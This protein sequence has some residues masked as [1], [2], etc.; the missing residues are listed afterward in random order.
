MSLLEKM[1]KNSTIKETSIL[2]T[3]KFFTK[4]DVIPTSIPALNVALSGNLDGGMVPGISLFCGPSK[5]F[6]SFFC[7]ILAKAY[8]DKYPDSVLVFYDCE[9]GTPDT[10]FQS[11]NMDTDRILHTPIMNM[12]EF[13]FDIMKHLQNIT[14]EDK[15]IFVVDSIGSMSSLKEGV[16]AIE[17]KSTQDMTR[18]KQM[19]SIFRMVTP[20]LVRNDIPLVAVNH[21]YMEQGSMYPKTIVSGGTGIYLSADNIYIMGRQQEKEGTEVTGYNFIINIEKSRHVR[22]KSKIPISVKFEGGISR[23]SGLIDMALESGHVIKPSNGW[24]SRVNIETGEVEEKKYRL[25]D[26]D[27]K[28]FWSKIL[29]DKTF[30]KWVEDNYKLAHGNMLSSDDIDKTFATIDDDEDE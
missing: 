30:H 19:K 3:S 22:E 5:H 21:I 15:I 13:K 9:F 11:L 29:L 24:Y 14:R 4:K 20:Y 6:K 7:L 12:E 17:G 1:K 10:Y 25:K 8:M 2:T 26:T 23:W 16:D 18:A 28:D 27:N